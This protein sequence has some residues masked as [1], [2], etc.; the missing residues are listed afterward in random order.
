[1]RHLSMM[2]VVLL[3]LAG[4]AGGGDPAA[5]PPTGSTALG[6]RAVPGYAIEVRRLPSPDQEF[7]FR[8]DVAADDGGPAPV[9][10]EAA[11][12]STEPVAWTPGT[13]VPGSA[14]AWT[15]S[16]GGPAREGARVWIRITDPAGNQAQS[17]EGDFAVR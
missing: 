15:W 14:T 6:S 13:A 3:V 2:L 16:D 5:Q 4:C 1:M 8:A 7:A 11:V 10:V 12:S 9:L 17:G